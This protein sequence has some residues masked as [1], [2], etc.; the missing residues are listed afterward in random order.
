MRIAFL[1]APEGVEQAE[2]TGPWQAAAETGETPQ[3]ISTRPGTVRS[4]NHLDWGETFPVDATAEQASP[5][6]FDAL[7]L[8]G[9]VANPDALRLDEAA[10][11]FAR[12]FFEAGKPV[13]AICHA[14]WTLIEADVV[15]GRTLTSWPSLR[16]DLRNAGATWVDEPVAVDDSGPNTL[17]T[18]RKPA[19]IPQ[20]NDAM[21][22]E[23]GKVAA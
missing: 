23:F 20:F 16:T 19:D 15:R 14:P 17:V 7:V 3:L 8:P 11:A 4:M 18:S 10:V 21:L 13:A 5:E 2:L 12:A 1:T 9:G 6:E 22:R